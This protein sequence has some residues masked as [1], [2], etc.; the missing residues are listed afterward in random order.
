MN[1]ELKKYFTSKIT[2]QIL[3]SITRFSESY[4]QINEV[5]FLI[6][7][8]YNTKLDEL[9][10]VFNTNSELVEKIKNKTIDIDK[11][12]YLKPDE[13]NPDKYKVY[14]Q[15]KEKEFYKKMNTATT[16]MFT[17]KKCKSKKCIVSE[18]QTRSGDEPATTFV[19][20]TVCDYCFKF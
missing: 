6:Q 16:D 12:C 20:C 18:K 8:I 2:K 14:L 7:E 15:K 13:L 11:I 3:E 17:C 1:T 10:K 9:I 5:D 4:A 19:N